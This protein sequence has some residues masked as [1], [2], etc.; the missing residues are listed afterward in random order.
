MT[1]IKVFDGNS[2]IPNL[3]LTKPGFMDTT[4]E[5]AYPGRVGFLMRKLIC[6]LLLTNRKVKA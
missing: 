1:I 6:T 4:V 5:H 3:T 2:N